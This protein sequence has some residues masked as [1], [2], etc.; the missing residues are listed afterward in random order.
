ML[1]YVSIRLHEIK[2]KN[3]KYNIKTCPTTVQHDTTKKKKT[4][5]KKSQ[6][7]SRMISNNIF[8]AFFDNNINVKVDNTNI[9]TKQ[10]QCK[11]KFKLFLHVVLTQQKHFFLVISF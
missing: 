10:I 11:F 5:F 1:Y 2:N 4:P 8:Q 6:L 9:K 7:L 3:R